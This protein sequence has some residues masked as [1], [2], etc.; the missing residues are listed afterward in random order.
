MEAIFR[1]KKVTD[2]C[3]SL[4]KRYINKEEV[5]WLMVR[6]L[7]I[8]FLPLIFLRC[9]DSGVEPPSTAPSTQ[10]VVNV[11]WGDEG[12]PGIP[13][14]LLGRADSVNTDSSGLAKFSVPPGKY[15]VRAFGINRGG[16]AYQHI[17]VEVEATQGKTS[18][19]DIVD[20]LPCL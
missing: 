14:V 8:L 19:V 7:F 12:I 9:S 20:C 18:L 13:V 3:F 5:L 16:P 15:V 10:I 6:Q 4:L 17:D 11:H 1:T 2:G